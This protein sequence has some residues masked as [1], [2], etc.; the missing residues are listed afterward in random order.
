MDGVLANFNKGVVDILNID[1]KKQG[2]ASGNY[3]DFLYHEMRKHEHFYY[4]LEP[5]KD[6][7]K[8]P[9][10]CN[11]PKVILIF[12]FSS[13]KLSV[14][15]A[16]QSIDDKRIL[17]IKLSYTLFL[18]DFILLVTIGTIIRAAILTIV[19]TTNISINVKAFFIYYLYS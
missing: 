11:V 13:G 8:Y 16:A 9:F 4:H 10:D 17:L 5:F 19:I 7:L 1:Y 3:H 18:L 2:E 15:S 6:V 14:L 12:S